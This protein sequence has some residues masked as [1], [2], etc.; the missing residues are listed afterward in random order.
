[1]AAVPVTFHLLFRPSLASSFPQRL[2]NVNAAW[3]TW[4]STHSTEG[5]R[6]D[7]SQVFAHTFA[8]GASVAAPSSCESQY[9]SSSGSWLVPF[10]FRLC[11]NF[12]ILLGI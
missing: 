12:D 4:C 1:M 9:Q 5:E 7:C 6:V 8:Y 2:E 11:S 10:L 3:A